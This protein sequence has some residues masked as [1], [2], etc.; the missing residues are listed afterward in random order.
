M[1]A[2]SLKGE[3]V[4][5]SSRE[6]EFVGESSGVEESGGLLSTG[7]DGGED[8]SGV[9]ESCGLQSTGG[10]GGGV[11]L[12]GVERGGRFLLVGGVGSLQ[13]VIWGM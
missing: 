2:A 4:F 6:V 10:D 5:R 12:L 7:G 9:E 13:L 1:S 11:L 8:S 3:L